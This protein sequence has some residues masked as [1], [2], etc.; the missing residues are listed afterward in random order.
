MSDILKKIETYKRDEIAAAK[1]SVPLADLK[2]MIAGRDAPRSFARALQDRIA[3]GRPA[4]IAEIKKASPSQ[5]LIRADFDPFVLAR[6]YE[7]GGAAWNDGWAVGTPRGTR[8]TRVG[9]PRG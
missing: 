6:A 9:K 4:L 5:G 2:A 1:L 7:A 3:S 8:Q